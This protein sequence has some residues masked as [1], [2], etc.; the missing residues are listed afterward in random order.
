MA[1]RI[2]FSRHWSLPSGFSSTDL[3][4]DALPI[5]PADIGKENFVFSDLGSGCS[6]CHYQ[7]G[8]YHVLRNRVTIDAD[9]PFLLFRAPLTGRSD[10]V[11]ESVGSIQESPER[12]GIFVHGNPEDA[13]TSVHLA[14]EVM[15]VAAIMISA[16]RLRTMCE[17]LDLPGPLKSL[18]VGRIAN[19]MSELKMSATQRRLFTEIISN[20]Y[21]GGLARLYGEGKVLEITAAILAELG[22]SESETQRLLGGVQAKFKAACEYLLSNLIDLPSQ[23]LLAREVGLPQRQLAIAFRQ[24]TGMTMTEWIL[25]KKLERAAEMLMVGDLAI[26][27]IAYRHGYSQV[28]AFTAAFS[29]RYGCPPASYRKLL[30]IKHYL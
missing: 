24:A 22:G 2:S 15:S 7:G 18:D 26:K 3:P 27:E 4:G 12:I 21:S 17:G 10:F 5:L 25:E 6:A 30:V 14:N 23:E 29:S 11:F 28:S 8:A 19:A 1:Q 16:S 13:C 9:E 20:P